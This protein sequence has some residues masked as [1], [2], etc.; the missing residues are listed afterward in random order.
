MMHSG[1]MASEHASRNKMASLETRAV[2]WIRMPCAERIASAIKKP[3]GG[4]RANRVKDAVSAC[5][6]FYLAILFDEMKSSH[7]FKMVSTSQSRAGQTVFSLS[8][9]LRRPGAMPHFEH[10]PWRIS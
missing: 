7:L 3:P 5:G 9:N 10:L 6:A 2:G 8:K 4:D 1:P